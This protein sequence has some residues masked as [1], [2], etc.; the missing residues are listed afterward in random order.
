MNNSIWDEF[1][2][3]VLRSNDTLLHLIFINLAIFVATGL[4]YVLFRWF[5]LSPGWFDELYRWL[6][7]PS[8]PLT[9][10]TRPWTLVSYQFIHSMDSWLHIIFNMLILFWFGRIFM[11][12]LGN[13]KLLSVYLAGGIAGA[14]L[15]ILIYNLVPLFQRVS[16]IS[17]L[18]GASASVLAILVATATL[19][20]DYSIRLILIGAVRL[21]Y[22]ALFLV[23]I[24]LLSMAGSNAGG[25]IAHLGG[26]A[27]G[28]IYI[29]Q[30]QSGRDIGQWVN[31]LVDWLG[32]FFR[33][34]P[35]LRVSDMGDRSQ[36]KKSGG[37]SEVSQE[38]I[39]A[40]LDKIA[41]SGYDSLTK[42][43]KDILFKA[44]NKD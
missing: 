37:L 4:L 31:L 36:P 9:L 22:I 28:F 15:Y 24:D 7:V 10:L 41:K 3:R 12:Y 33:K 6:A 32:G 44:S 35:N 40:I 5:L 39:D 27:Y 43:E 16:D 13:R 19:L 18:Y 38:Q 23:I 25:S 14:L 42:K 2:L 11:E 30:L 8:N 29:R 34:G 21:K 17:I 26:A 1:K 20:P